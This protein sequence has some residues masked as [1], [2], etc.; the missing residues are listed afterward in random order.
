MATGAV[1]GV[2]NWEWPL[3]CAHVVWG[4]ACYGS[5]RGPKVLVRVALQHWALRTPGRWLWFSNDTKKNTRSPQFQCDIWTTLYRFFV[6]SKL[7]LC[8]RLFLPWLMRPSKREAVLLSHKL[9]LDQQNA[10]TVELIIHLKKMSN[11]T[12]FTPFLILLWLIKDVVVLLNLISA[13][14]VCGMIAN[15]NT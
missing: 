9:Y 10:Y 13:K 12:L 15:S 3:F 14:L 7:Y 4:T 8:V 5:A 6:F 1:S 11:L 2:Q